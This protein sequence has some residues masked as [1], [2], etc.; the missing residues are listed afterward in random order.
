M[1]F[2]CAMFCSISERFAIWGEFGKDLSE[3]LK[4]GLIVFHLR[5]RLKTLK[6]TRRQENEAKT[7]VCI[8]LD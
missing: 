2:T 4:N 8:G 1:A 5:R 7:N 3:T 6:P